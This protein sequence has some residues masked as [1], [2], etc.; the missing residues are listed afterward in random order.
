MNDSNERGDGKTGVVIAVVLILLLLP[1]VVG[2]LAV[3]GAIFVYRASAVPQ[4]QPPAVEVEPAIPEIAP[5][6]EI[7][8]A[9]PEV[10]QPESPP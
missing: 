6:P 8:P 3:G 1:C 7:A 10:A 5:V 4:P 9:P 2:V